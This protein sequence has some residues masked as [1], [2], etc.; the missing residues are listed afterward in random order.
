M[1]HVTGD[2]HG[3]ISRFSEA[4]LQGESEWTKDDYIIVCG[5]FGFIFYD[6][7]E[8]EK[9]L[10]LLEK[11]PYNILFIDGN[12]ENFNALEGLWHRPW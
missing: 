8:E 2:T 4:F 7:E 3:E 11:K 6:D 9:M 1:V 12:H 5:D 10:D